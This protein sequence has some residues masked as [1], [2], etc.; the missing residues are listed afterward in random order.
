MRRFY[1]V[2]KGL[3]RNIHYNNFYKLQFDY[4]NVGLK[5]YKK[6][7]FPIEC[8]GRNKHGEEVLE[9]AVQIDVRIFKPHNLNTIFGLVGCKYSIG[10]NM[11]MCRAANPDEYRFGEGVC[12]YVF[13]IPPALE[14]KSKPNI[15]LEWGYNISF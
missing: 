8:L 6:E 4:N 14:K 12:P 9:N 2:M 5:D 15:E 1:R 10:E 13:E 11:E 3:K 7:D